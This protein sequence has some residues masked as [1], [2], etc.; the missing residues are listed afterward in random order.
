MGKQSLSQS[1]ISRQVTVHTHLACSPHT[2]GV[3]QLPQL[4]LHNPPQMAPVLKLGN[5]AQV[6]TSPGT[7]RQMAQ[8]IP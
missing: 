5:S 4:T 7:A 3:K 1:T 2:A 6:M 8:A